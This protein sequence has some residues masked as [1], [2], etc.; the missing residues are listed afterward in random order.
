MTARL[1]DGRAISREIRDEIRS[2][3]SERR[4]AGHRPPGLAV[5]L[6][7][8]DQASQ[9]YVRNKRTAC[10]EVGI[11][12]RDYDLPRETT[13]SGAARGS[14]PS[15]TTIPP[16]TAFSCSCLCRRTSTSWRSSSTSVL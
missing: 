15:S 11:A 12:S 16:S 6:V 3:V 5:L 8:S 10:E 2:R 1:I 7:G 14:S 13:E 9:I 4:S